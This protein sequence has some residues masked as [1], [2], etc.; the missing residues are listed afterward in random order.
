MGDHLITVPYTNFAEEAAPLRKELIQAFERVLDSGRYILGPQLAA[1]EAEFAQ[2]CGTS[3]AAGVGSGTD[4]LHLALR[5][6]GVGAGDEVITA[7][8]SFVATAAAIA[9]TGARPIFAD[10]LHD[11]NLDPVRAEAAITSRTKAIIPVHLTGRPAQMLEI[12]AIAKR[13]G[14]CVIEDAAQAVGARF[15]GRRVGGWSDIACFSLNPLKNL[16][17]FGDGGVVTTNSEALYRRIIQ[18]RSHGLANR[19][20]CDFWSFNTRLDEV[21]AAWLRVQLPHL[22]QWTEARR[23]LAFRYNDLLRNYVEVPEEGPDEYCVYQTYVVRTE[24][25]D[26]LQ[27]YLRENGVEALVHYAT[28]IH[29]QPAAQGLRYAATDFPDTMRCVNR[30]LSLPLY[31]GLSDVQQNRVANLIG[32]FCRSQTGPN[33]LDRTATGVH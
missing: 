15:A 8:N 3:Y 28:A 27:R 9:L 32:R 12:V 30:I 11:G 16:R 33:R 24:Q 6:L 19:E 2:Y 14:L 18:M 1:F 4:A 21:Q 5:A 25:R 29:Q 7:P 10:I 20:Q 17:A 13:H 26:E 31:P 23:R 22:D